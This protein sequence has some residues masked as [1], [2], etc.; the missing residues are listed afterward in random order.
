MEITA[1]RI[2]DTAANVRTDDEVIVGWDSDKMSS[3]W[4]GDF[5][6]TPN[7]FHMFGRHVDGWERRRDVAIR[8]FGIGSIDSDLL[9]EF[10]YL[11]APGGVY[12]LVDSSKIVYVGY[13][14]G[15]M[16]RISSHLFA[17]K[18]QF[19][20]IWYMSGLGDWDS[21]GDQQFACDHNGDKICECS[22]VNGNRKA[23]RDLETALIAKFDPM[24]N[25]HPNLMLAECFD[26]IV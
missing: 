13:S 21:W 24:Y 23:W 17:K 7:P 2:I 25:R 1:E 3:S 16:A 6:A 15:L 10:Y 18:K 12:A 11:S 9:E 4:E 20:S 14:S 22:S 26:G 5:R 8:Y 19:T